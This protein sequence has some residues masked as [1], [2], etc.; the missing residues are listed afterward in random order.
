DRGHAHARLRE[1]ARELLR[2]GSPAGLG[3]GRDPRR[4]PRA[5]RARR[6]VARE[7]RRRADPAPRGLAA[8]RSPTEEKA[9]TERAADPRREAFGDVRCVRWLRTSSPSVVR[10]RDVRIPPGRLAAARATTRSRVLD[11]RAVGERRELILRAVRDLFRDLVAPD[12][13]ARRHLE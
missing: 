2:P 13:L 5:A 11:L 7:R 12:V 1:R 6:T 4:R 10:L 8:D 9:T 3:A